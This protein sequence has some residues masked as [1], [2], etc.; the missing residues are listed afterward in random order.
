MVQED[1][2]CLRHTEIIF[3]FIFGPLFVYNKAFSHT[4]ASVSII[5]GKRLG[6]YFTHQNHTCASV[7]K[8]AFYGLKLHGFII[9]RR[10]A[11]IPGKC[12]FIEAVAKEGGFMPQSGAVA[13]MYQDRGQK[14][15]LIFCCGLRFGS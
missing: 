14:C 10:V 12:I 2:H 15:N 5:K 8:L 7:V 13:L 6:A 9:E 4:L 1:S 11:S 3:Y